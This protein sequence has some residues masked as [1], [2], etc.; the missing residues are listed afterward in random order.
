MW[1]IERGRGGKGRF[2]F[3]LGV[4]KGEGLNV[5]KSRYFAPSNGFGVRP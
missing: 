4:G 2:L 3:L 5:V 1:I